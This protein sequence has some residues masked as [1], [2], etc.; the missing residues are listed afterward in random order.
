MSAP[1]ARVSTVGA[2]TGMKTIAME[3]HHISGIAV[4]SDATNRSLTTLVLHFLFF[5]KA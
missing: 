1:P 4:K 2:R 5:D 3:S